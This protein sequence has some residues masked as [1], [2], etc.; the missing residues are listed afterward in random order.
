MSIPF[1]IP[2]GSRAGLWDGGRAE[3]HSLLSHLPPVPPDGPTLSPGAVLSD[4]GVPAAAPPAPHSSARHVSHVSCG[5]AAPRPGP[6]STR[7]P[8][9]EQH[10]SLPLF[11]L[12][13]GPL[14][15][16]GRLP[17][18]RRG[19]RPPW[20]VCLVAAALPLTL[21]APGCS[22]SFCVIGR[23]ETVMCVPGED[24][25]SISFQS[26]GPAGAE[27]GRSSLGWGPGEGRALLL[28][29][30]AVSL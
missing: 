13:P 9:S 23:L 27:V 3:A 24:Q 14:S 12:P 19:R 28:S 7:L 20:R 11:P 30:P 21:R 29:P 5:A 25:G 1:R 4:G 2:G 6:L 15:P 10:S 16:Q 17:S 26:V 8:P 18:A 22:C